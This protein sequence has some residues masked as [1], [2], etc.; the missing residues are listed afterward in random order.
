MVDL[1]KIFESLHELLSPMTKKKLIWLEGGSATNG[2]C[3][4]LTPQPSCR[5]LVGPAEFYP[6]TEVDWNNITWNK[7]VGREDGHT[8][9]SP[10]KP[11]LRW[12]GLGTGRALGYPYKN[13]LTQHAAVCLPEISYD[14]GLW[15]TD[16]TS[17]S[18]LTQLFAQ[19]EQEEMWDVTL[20]ALVPD[21]CHPFPF[22][23]FPI[24]SKAEVE[25]EP[26]VTH[27]TCMGLWAGRVRV[28]KRKGKLI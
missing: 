8:A 13:N 23:N 24:F 9:P 14:L 26:A 3:P 17:C 15:A 28:A 2:A 1:A 19:P 21:V 16:W 20:A 5:K 7:A 25:E 27:S 22:S 12:W 18:N 11:L 4:L 6:N 10:W